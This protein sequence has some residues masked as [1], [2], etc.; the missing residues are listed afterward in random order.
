[1]GQYVLS[2]KPE[3]CSSYPH[4]T[5]A[6]L[7]GSHTVNSQL[8]C[9]TT[10]LLRAAPHSP[11]SQC[12]SPAELPLPKIYVFEGRKIEHTQETQSDPSSN[13]GSHSQGLRQA[14]ARGSIQV[15]HRVAGVSVLG[16]TLL[17]DTP[18][19][20]WIRTAGTK[21][22]GFKRCHREWVASPADQS[23][24]SPAV[25]N[26]W[27]TSDPDSSDPGRPRVTAPLTEVLSPM[28]ETQTVFNEYFKR[29]FCSY[30]TRYIYVWF[31]KSL[32]FTIP[33][34]MM[35]FLMGPNW[36]NL[37]FSKMQFNRYRGSF[38]TP[39]SLISPPVIFLWIIMVYSS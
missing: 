21:T 24:A 19:G 32:M 22:D 1:M 31:Y 6:W 38:S 3:P 15:S 5:V 39:S 29:T 27:W 35:Y 17:S 37:L 34:V 2:G 14:E 28:W 18:T 12:L 33:H 36:V 13:N 25:F 30:S 11:Y 8:P 9:K 20:R 26:T 7:R 10:N 4:S 16:Y 23:P